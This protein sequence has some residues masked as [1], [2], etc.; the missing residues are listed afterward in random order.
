M[1]RIIAGRFIEQARAEAAMEKLVQA[2]FARDQVTSF[3]VNSPGKHDTYA[4]GGDEDVSPGAE[5]GG[6]GAAAGAVGGGAAG[7]AAG[8]FLGP[9]GA[10]AGAAVGAY[11]GSMQGALGNMEGKAGDDDNPQ[12]VAEP[13][14]RSAGMMV[15]AAMPEASSDALA[16]QV[17]RTA[18]AADLER[19]SGTITG[20]DWVDF[21]PLST[22]HRI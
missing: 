3:F 19:G 5:G 6:M 9:A 20:G 18:G 7:A 10:L 16:I 17:L 12:L 14:T 13:E 22:V 4:I 21:D 1:A 2:G 11:V 15:A 8:A